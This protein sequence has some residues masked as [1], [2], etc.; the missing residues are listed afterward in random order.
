MTMKMYVDQLKA[1]S[2]EANLRHEAAKA[3]KQ[4]TDKRI[5][6]DKPLTEQITELMA[7]LPPAQRDRPWSME[8]LVARL[9]G[10][11]N[12]RP[13]AMHVGQALRQLGWT[14]VRQWSVQ[15]AGRR[16]WCLDRR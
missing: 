4:K 6:C 8:E 16:V 1:N 3:K 10:R 15:G 5:L 2:D 12:M 9:K 7:S 11:Y 14:T 13:H